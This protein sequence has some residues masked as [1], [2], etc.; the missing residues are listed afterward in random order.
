LPSSKK[1]SSTS[2]EV[3]KSS[4]NTKVF[5]DQ[6][7]LLDLF[8]LYDNFD[9]AEMVVQYHL[10]EIGKWVDPILY[11]HFDM[12]KMLDAT[13]SFRVNRQEVSEIPMLRNQ[14]FLF[15]SGIHEQI[16]MLNKIS[17]KLDQVLRRVD[18]LISERSN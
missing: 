14:V 5:Q 3:I 17:V 2:F 12:E 16:M 8:R 6:K 7:M 9:H 13:I 10:D 15:R 11:K 18:E 1:P 4:G